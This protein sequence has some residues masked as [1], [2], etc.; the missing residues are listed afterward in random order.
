MRAPDSELRGGWAASPTADC[1]RRERLAAICV[2]AV[3]SLVLCGTA[4]AQTPTI[5]MPSDLKVN[6]PAADVP[7]NV[8]RFVGAWAHGVWDGVLP[9]VLV[10]ETVDGTGR[11]QVV[12]A[13]GDSA[14]AN[15]TRGTGA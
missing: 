4:A 1:W 2:V 15:V 10:I 11:A 8:S 14:E 13:V 6:P 5:P 3:L 7:T 12:Y 9:H